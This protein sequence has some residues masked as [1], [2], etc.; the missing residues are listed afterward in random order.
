MA[1][2][3]DQREHPRIDASFRVRSSA[4]DPDA[5]PGD[6]VSRGG[7]FVKTVRF[8]PLNAVIR[9]SIEAP[10]SGIAVPATCRVAF[11]RDAATSAAAGKPAGMGL[12]LLDIT[13][14]NRAELARGSSRS[15]G[16]RLP[17][18]SVR[19]SLEGGALRVVVVDDD[20]RYREQAAE[21]FRKRGET[22]CSP[23]R[24]GSRG[25][26]RV[27]QGNHPTSS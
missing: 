25:A 8:L 3:R 2:T 15:A 10:E 13:D 11:V 20:A 14:A 24:T 21:P 16:A 23:P 27:H 12:E 17:P 19:T 4:I 7:I 1:G 26:G 6:N 9:L 18:R 5:L 22:R